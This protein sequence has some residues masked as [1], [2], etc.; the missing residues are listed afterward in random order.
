MSSQMS[1]KR[2]QTVKNRSA[3]Q[4]RIRQGHASRWTAGCFTAVAESF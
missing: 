4:K 3:S 2:F 1:S